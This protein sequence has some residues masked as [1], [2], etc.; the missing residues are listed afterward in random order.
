MFKF[1]KRN[2]GNGQ[3]QTIY[4]SDVAAFAERAILSLESEATS[5]LVDNM[6]FNDVRFGMAC[7]SFSLHGVEFGLGV[8]T[9]GIQSWVTNGNGETMPSLWQGKLS[10]VKQ[11]YA[12]LS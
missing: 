5:D 12:E 4:L 6:L 9:N 8:V 1:W 7:R 2:R 10:I 3:E 11:V